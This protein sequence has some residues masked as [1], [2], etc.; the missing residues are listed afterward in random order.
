M[1]KSK[2]K[3]DKIAIPGLFG[4][5]GKVEKKFEA[6]AYSSKN[7]TI[8]EVEAGRAVVNFQFLKDLFEAIMMQGV[9]YLVIAVRTIYR[10]K[11]DF[12]Y[13]KLFF[14]SLYGCIIQFL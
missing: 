5:G 11:K 9:D 1:E 10:R 3:K 8:I 7:S 4:I 6:D 12:D 2:K 13:V 14:E